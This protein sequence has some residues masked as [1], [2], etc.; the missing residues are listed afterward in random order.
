MGDFFIIITIKYFFIIVKMCDIHVVTRCYSLSP[1][2]YKLHRF[3][4]RFLIINLATTRL[5][6]H[7]CPS[8][9]VAQWLPLIASVE[10]VTRNELLP[11]FTV[12]QCMSYAW[13]S[14]ALGILGCIETDPA[15]FSKKKTN[16]GYL[17]F[18]F[19]KIVS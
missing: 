1:T 5:I 11:L 16:M 18:V 7:Y 15:R 2:N 14:S 9:S 6:S 17:S 13:I 10:A 3:I 4:Y 8:R 12:V 19:I